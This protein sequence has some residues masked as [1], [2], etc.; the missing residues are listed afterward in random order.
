MN[1]SERER[2]SLVNAF[3]A[4]G[5]STAST[6]ACPEATQIYDAVAGTLS[7]QERMQILDHVSQCAECAEAWKIAKE[8]DAG[9][10]ERS[11]P[12]HARLT[13]F[14]SLQRVA[15]AATVVIAVAFTVMVVVPTRDP[16]TQYRTAADPTVPT[17]TSA[18]RLPRER[19]LL[20]WTPGPA[21]STYALRLSTIELQ[22]VYSQASIAQTEFVVPGDALANVKSQSQLLWQVEAQTPGGDRIV[23]DTFEVTVE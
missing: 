6:T 19:F 11:Q 21:G 1:P 12:W 23:S 2:Q 8:I 16:A 5:P 20:Q 22:I 18:E 14:G 4:R 13:S 7:V 15:A 9:A 10:D 17:S 3:A